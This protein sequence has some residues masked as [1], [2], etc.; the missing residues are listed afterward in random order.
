MYPTTLR[1]WLVDPGIVPAFIPLASTLCFD[2]FKNEASLVSFVF[3]SIFRDLIY[4]GWDDQ[5]GIP[6]SD[7]DQFK[8]D[9]IPRMIAAIDSPPGGLQSALDALAIAY[10][11]TL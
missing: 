2:W 5:Q 1:Q 6:T 11:S 10:H 3:R 9:V 4:R 7:W 8:A